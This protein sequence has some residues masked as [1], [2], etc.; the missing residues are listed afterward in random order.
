VVTSSSVGKTEK[1]NTS[2]VNMVSSTTISEKAR[3]NA[4]S[5]SRKIGGNG[6]MIISIINIIARAIKTSV[7]FLAPIVELVDAI[8]SPSSFL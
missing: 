1:S 6:I 3:L 5:T 2:L 8:Q 4:M 7:F